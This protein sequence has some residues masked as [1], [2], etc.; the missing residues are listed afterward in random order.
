MLEAQRRLLTASHKDSV[1]DAEIVGKDYRL[2]PTDGVL[3]RRVMV[4]KA[5]IWVPVLPATA[6]PQEALTE[7]RADLT[8]RRWAFERAHETFL[9]PHR[10]SGATWQVLKRLGFWPEMHKDFN[11]WMNVF[12]SLP[13]FLV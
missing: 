1:K 10:P 13:S 12:S 8:W 11:I 5:D 6:I 9:E 3:E 7:V 2:H 4:Q